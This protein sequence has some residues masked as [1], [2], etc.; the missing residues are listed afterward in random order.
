[1]EENIGTKSIQILNNFSQKTSSLHRTSPHIHTPTKKHRRR[2]CRRQIFLVV[3]GKG[4]SKQRK[5]REEKKTNYKT[6]RAESVELK[7]L[8][9]INRRSRAIRAETRCE[10][11][12]SETDTEQNKNGR[13]THAAKPRV[14]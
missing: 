8:V 1:M 3:S 12:T 13:R 10:N 11:K 6:T 2:I 4:R 14:I 9:T 7:K 5:T